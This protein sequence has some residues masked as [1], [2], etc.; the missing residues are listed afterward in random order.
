MQELNGI[1][2]DHSTAMVKINHCRFAQ[3]LGQHVR[4]GCIEIRNYEQSHGPSGLHVE[5][6]NNVFDSNEPF[7]IACDTDHNLHCD[8]QLNV[9]KG[10]NGPLHELVEDANQLN[11]IDNA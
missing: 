4:I 1:N 8:A 3:L 5:I 6:I 7:P 2:I 9:L 10:Q 11:I